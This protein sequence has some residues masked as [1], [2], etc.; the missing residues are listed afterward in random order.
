MKTTIQTTREEASLYS[1]FLQNKNAKQN[2]KQ[3]KMKIFYFQSI[4]RNA[5]KT[6]TKNKKSLLTTD[7]LVL[8]TMKNAAKRDM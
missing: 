5:L 6:K 1:F 7:V 2:K 8:V 4:I 3:N